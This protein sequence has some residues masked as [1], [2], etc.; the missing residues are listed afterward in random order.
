MK[1]ENFSILENVDT[2]TVIIELAYISNPKEES[3]L[4]SPVYQTKF[5]QAIASGINEYFQ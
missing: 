2:P 4:A 1:P 5:A 3:L